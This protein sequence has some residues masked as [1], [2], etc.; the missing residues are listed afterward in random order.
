[1]GGEQFDRRWI[2]L[3]GFAVV[4]AVIVGVIVI[5]HSSGS[6]S[7]S[8]ATAG[9]CKEVELPEP[10]AEETLAKPKQTV[11]KGEKLTA[12]VE[13]NCGTFDIA[14]DTAQAPITTN[15]FAYLT[16]QGFYDEV[17]FTRIAPELVI[18]GGDP[19][20]TGSGG[21]GYSVVEEPPANIKYTKGVVGMAKS[22]TEAPGTSSSQFFVVTGT[23]DAFAPE[24]ALLGHISKG[25]NV[26]ERIGKLGNAEEKPTKN[27]VIEK[28]SIERG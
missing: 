18:Q 24:Y 2:I 12:V 23:E 21:P 15:S 8:T 27:V 26:V 19:T 25:M 28:L 7:S 6:S 22:G 4:A 13:T 16:E 1:M 10:R 20:Q 14:L 3:A 5:A 11:K 9:G 17:P